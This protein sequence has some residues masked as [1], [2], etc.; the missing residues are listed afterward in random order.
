MRQQ[1]ILAA[2]AAITII[3]FSAATPVRAEILEPVPDSVI[4]AQRAALAETSEGAGFGP[5]APRDIDSNEGANPIVFATAP[6]RT[7]MNLCNI[8]FHE[9]A[10]HKGGEF[11][12][13]AGNGDGEGNGTGYLYSGQLTQEELRPLGVQVGGGPH[14]DLK[15]GDTIEAHYVYSTAAVA[16]G[17]TLNACMDDVTV[18]PQLRVEAFVFVLVNDETAADFT[19]LNMVGEAN[20]YHQAINLPT[21]AGKPV[22]YI[23]S[24]TGPVYNEEASPFQVSWSVRPKVIKVNISSVDSW[25][26]DN[27]FEEHGAHGVRNLVVNPALLSP[28]EQ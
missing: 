7:R 6:D 9:G 14:G 12:N 5:Q 20:G 1:K 16:P 13:Y 22:N 4:D 2:A 8:H 15:P 24:T 21:G 11:T 28:I 3:T 23:G 18:N 25:L 19:E 27:P 17:P 10:E 26:K